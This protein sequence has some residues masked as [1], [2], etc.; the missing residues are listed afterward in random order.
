MKI[1]VKTRKANMPKEEA[2]SSAERFPADTFLAG[3]VAFKASGATNEK[4]YCTQLT[5]MINLRRII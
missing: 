3:V 2:I 5:F 4:A 1:N